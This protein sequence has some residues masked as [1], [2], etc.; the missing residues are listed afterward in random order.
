MSENFM[1]IY[2][3]FSIEVVGIKDGFKKNFLFKLGFDAQMIRNKCGRQGI[4][5]RGV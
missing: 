5:D 1:Y 2:I 4:L 3:Y